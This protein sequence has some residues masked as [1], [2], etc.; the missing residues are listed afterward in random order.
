MKIIS[1]EQAIRLHN[2]LILKI[3]GLDGVRDNN[4]LSSALSSPFQ[5]FGDIELY[6]SIHEKA[7]RLAYNLISNHAFVDGNKRI[8]TYIMII[9]LNINNV[10]ITIT[11]DELVALGLGIAS[12]EIN[13][14]EVVSWI[15]EHTINDYM[16][17]DIQ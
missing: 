12:C 5:S 17:I 6:P 10:K 15:K 11:D 4:L 2:M 13:Y 9:F 1:E 16:N 7:A 14:G 8:G 3:G